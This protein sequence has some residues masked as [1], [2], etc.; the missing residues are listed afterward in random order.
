LNIVN[1]GWSAP[2]ESCTS[3]DD[4]IDNFMGGHR[5][6]KEEVGVEQ[7]K[8]SW[9]LDSFGVSKGFAR[10][11]KDIG[12]DAMFY[13]RTDPEDFHEHKEKHEYINIWRSAE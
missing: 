11:F 3:Y 13:T 10:L 1:G 2:D 12:M 8:I 6:L 7:P 4:V 5:F 9:Q